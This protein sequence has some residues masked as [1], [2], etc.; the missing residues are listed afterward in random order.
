MGV[1]KKKEKRDLQLRGWKKWLH[2]L[3]LF[4]TYP[5]RKPLIILF[6][7]IV[8]FLAPTFRGVKPA[9]VHLWYWGKIKAAFS[10]VSEIVS[11]KTQEFIP[12]NI[13]MPSLQDFKGP[14]KA[15]EQVVDMPENT[16]QSVRRK[17]F[18]KARDDQAAIQSVDILETEETA[19][20]PQAVPAAGNDIQIPAA[21]VLPAG[22]VAI[23]RNETTSVLSGQIQPP[24][25][26]KLP[27]VY[28]NRT[29]EISGKARVNN[30]NE[31]E[32]K[33]KTVFLYGIY[34]DPRTQ[35]GIEAKNYLKSLIE[36]N[37]VF[38]SIPAYTYQ[39]IA[40]ARCQVNGVDINRALVDGGYSKNVALDD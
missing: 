25:K 3:F 19:H 23:R 21:P 8:M 9:E 22:D 2:K 13:S 14:E 1:F 29:E 20:V 34:V 4:V 6:I 30:A 26:K 16:P 37:E 40:T 27:L 5:F 11:K 18:E 10:S 35:K 24:E 28:L 12:E 17:M 33:G 39:G 7:L 15:I 32:I 36:D 31:L 38:C